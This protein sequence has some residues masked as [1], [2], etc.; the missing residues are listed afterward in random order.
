MW[1]ISIFFKFQPQR[2][3]ELKFEGVLDRNF[4]LDTQPHRYYTAGQL[5]CGRMSVLYHVGEG[6]DAGVQRCDA[7][8][9]RCDAMRRDVARQCARDILYLPFRKTKNRVRVHEIGGPRGISRRP[10][11]D[12]VIEYDFWESDS[13]FSTFLI[14]HIK[15]LL[16]R[17]SNPGQA[18]SLAWR[19]F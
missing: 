4:R 6:L 5:S 1:K 14:I 13:R 11:E 12:Y 15:D 7:M 2:F 18:V 3:A 8:R 17:G 10:P 9:Q 16:C 19:M